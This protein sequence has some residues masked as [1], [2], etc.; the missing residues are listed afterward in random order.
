MFPSSCKH[1]AN[2]LDQVKALDMTSYLQK[3]KEYVPWITA[4]SSL[5]YIGSMLEGSDD[6]PDA[7]KLYEVSWYFSS[8]F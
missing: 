6:Y 2:L 5:G 1:R 4:I 8:F 7:Y 3:E